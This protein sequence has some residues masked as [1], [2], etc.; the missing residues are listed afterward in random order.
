MV[1]TE[2]AAEGINLQFCS[3]LSILTYPGI[4]NVLNSV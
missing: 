1:A 2:A 3:W 4:R